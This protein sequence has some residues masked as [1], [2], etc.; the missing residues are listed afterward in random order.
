LKIELEAEKAA[1]QL[2]KDEVVEEEAEQQKEAPVKQVL[3]GDK[4]STPSQ[5]NQTTNVIVNVGNN[6][7]SEDDEEEE[8]TESSGSKLKPGS[9]MLEVLDIL[10][11]PETVEGKKW[12]YYG[13]E[14]CAFIGDCYVKFDSAGKLISQYGIEGQ[15]L[16]LKEWLKQ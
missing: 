3:S 8:E 2:E 15:Y 14:V 11:D 1:K 13:S 4:S 16:D 10:G 7:D 6:D 5:M 9:T 12:N